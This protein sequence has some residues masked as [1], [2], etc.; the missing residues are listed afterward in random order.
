MALCNEVGARS[1]TA[2]P[3][4]CPGFARGLSFA[5][6]ETKAGG[7]EHVSVIHNARQHQNSPVLETTLRIQH[8]N[9]SAS[10]FISCAL[11]WQ[12]LNAPQLPGAPFIIS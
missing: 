11:W 4:A 7:A 9:R 2:L 3:Q 10:I 5:Y 8:R 6:L 1:P 12:K